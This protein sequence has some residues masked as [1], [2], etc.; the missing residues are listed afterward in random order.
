MLFKACANSIA[1]GTNIFSLMRE[2]SRP[3]S[4]PEK[5]V[6]RFIGKRLAVCPARRGPGGADIAY[7]QEGM[8]WRTYC[9]NLWIQIEGRLK[10]ILANHS[11]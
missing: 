10:T 1:R 2:K 8:D 9:H 5:N 3:L 11:F 4:N 6:F 7:A